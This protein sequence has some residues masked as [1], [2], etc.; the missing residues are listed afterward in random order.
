MDFVFASAWPLHVNYGKDR[1][2]NEVDRK[3]VE[4][5]KLAAEVFGVCNNFFCFF[6]V[7]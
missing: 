6:S 1:N 4:L 2:C 7:V 3:K 5:V